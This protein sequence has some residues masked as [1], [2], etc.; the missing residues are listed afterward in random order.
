M[1]DMR[2]LIDMITE[3][4]APVNVIS[5]HIGTIEHTGDHLYV[6]FKNGDIYEYDDVDEDLAKE[7]LRSE[8]KGKFFWR[9]IR[10][11]VP[12]RKVTHVP[13]I[14][15]RVRW[16][17]N[18]ETWEQISPE[19]PNADVVVPSGYSIDTPDGAVYTWRGAQWV[20]QRTKRMATKQLAALLTAQAHK[21][22]RG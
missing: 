14:K 12:Y 15:P 20:D 8:S 22:I 11:D 19:Q 7:M 16:N 13:Q 4:I 6:T 17:W 9:Y 21:D 18:T 10:N 1:F 2:Y 3:A 5:S